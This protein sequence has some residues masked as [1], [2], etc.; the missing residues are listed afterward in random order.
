MLLYSEI[1][2]LRARG[3]L[4]CSA[5][6]SAFI[7][8][9]L[10]ADHNGLGQAHAF[11]QGK[12]QLEAMAGAPQPGGVLAAQ[13]EAV[14]VDDEL[15]D[16]AQR[17]DAGATP[18]GHEHLRQEGGEV[19]GID[20]VARGKGGVAPAG[21]PIVYQQFDVG[22]EHPTS[23]RATAPSGRTEVAGKTRA[24]SGARQNGTVGASETQTTAWAPGLRR[25]CAA[26]GGRCAVKKG[27]LPGGKRPLRIASVQRRAASATRFSSARAA[28]A[29]KNAGGQVSAASLS[30]GRAAAMSPFESRS[31]P[32]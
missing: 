25:P 3:C 28:A 8:G 4:A 24:N 29:S 14:Q 10:G 19:G 15:A 17:V 23:S 30:R 7:R 1:I 18:A 21:A 5:K 16:Q 2:H 13:A 6:L 11:F 9:A 32:R 26:P 22:M 27:A 12:L 31:S 20:V